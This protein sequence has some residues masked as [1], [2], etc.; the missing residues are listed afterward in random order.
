MFPEANILQA[1]LTL[2]GVPAST[3]DDIHTYLDNPTAIEKAYYYEECDFER[4]ARYDGP[5][6]AVAARQHHAQAKRLAKPLTQAER[7]HWGELCAKG[8]V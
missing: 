6:A 5:K 7:A 4:I 2:I 1:I 3:R 8:L